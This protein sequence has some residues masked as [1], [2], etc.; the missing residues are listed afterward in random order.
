M[1]GASKGMVQTAPYTSS[2]ITTILREMW[3]LRGDLEGIESV[4]DRH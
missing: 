3:E 1:P 2:V 4:V